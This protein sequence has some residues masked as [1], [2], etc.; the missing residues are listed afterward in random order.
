MLIP[1]D[2]NDEEDP[3]I[4]ELESSLELEYDPKDDGGD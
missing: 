2:D 4:L 1:T 3:F